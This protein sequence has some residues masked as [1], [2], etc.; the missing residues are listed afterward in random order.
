[1]DEAFS[2]NSKSARYS[3]KRRRNCRTVEDLVQH[4]DKFARYWQI[5]EYE[6]ICGQTLDGE[7][8]YSTEKNYLHPMVR[9]DKFWAGGHELGDNQNLQIGD[10]CEE[11][12]MSVSK[13]LDL[14]WLLPFWHAIFFEI[15][16]EVAAPERFK[17]FEYKGLDRPLTK[18]EELATKI[19]SWELSCGI[20]IGINTSEHDPY[21]C[22]GWSEPISKRSSGVD[23]SGCATKIWLSSDFWHGL[24]TRESDLDDDERACLRT[25]LFATIM[26]E[27]AHA[28]INAVYGASTAHLLGASYFPGSMVAEEGME[29]EGRIFGGVTIRKTDCDILPLGVQMHCFGS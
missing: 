3:A 21:D 7:V 11:V 5:K 9:E 29:L 1:M 14:H 12:C 4:R 2:S 17:Y 23:F 28:A 27:L 15:P 8:C 16:K 13:C 19:K 20:L 26:H 18:D 22:D 24:V 25:S 6:T 10:P